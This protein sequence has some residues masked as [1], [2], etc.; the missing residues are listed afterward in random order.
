MLREQLHMLMVL[1]I[2]SQSGYMALLYCIRDMK[3][4]W[5]EKDGVMSFC[6]HNKGMTKI[7]YV[8]TK[9]VCV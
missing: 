4:R 6:Y 3:N 5:D 2:K 9:V 8:D 1:R 7:I